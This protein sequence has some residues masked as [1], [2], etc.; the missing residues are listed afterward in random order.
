MPLLFIVYYLVLLYLIFLKKNKRINLA[1]MYSCRKK[2]HTR[3][4]CERLKGV[5]YESRSRDRTQY[6]VDR[7]NLVIAWMAV[8]KRG[9]IGSVR[10]TTGYW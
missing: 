1:G 9:Y 8:Y 2:P 7:R 10:Q 3:R 6:A 5:Q 4:I